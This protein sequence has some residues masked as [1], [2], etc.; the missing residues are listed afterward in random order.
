MMA[1]HSAASQGDAV[2]RLGLQAAQPLHDRRPVLCLLT[3]HSCAAPSAHPVEALVCPRQWKYKM[4]P[5]HT[6]ALLHGTRQWSLWM[7]GWWCLRRSSPERQCF[8]C[9]FKGLLAA[10]LLLLV[11]LSN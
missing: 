8:H 2:C 1:P 7:P 5:H 6:D 4:S 9:T 10:A 11:G 3:I